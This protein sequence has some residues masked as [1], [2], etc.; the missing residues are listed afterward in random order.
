MQGKIKSLRGLL[1][2]LPKIDVA[3]LVGERQ[4][5]MNLAIAEKGY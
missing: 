1:P 3:A 5:L 4:P 2:S